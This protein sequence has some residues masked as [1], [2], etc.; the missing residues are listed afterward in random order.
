MKTPDDRRVTC[1]PPR[2]VA[3]HCA[4][5]DTL[6]RVLV[7]SQDEWE[8]LPEAQRPSIAEFFPGLGWVVATPRCLNK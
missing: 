5:G 3:A 6:C 7:L 2:P 1:D 8:A 4:V